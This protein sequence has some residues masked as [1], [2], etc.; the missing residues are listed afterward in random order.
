MTRKNEWHSR[1]LIADFLHEVYQTLDDFIKIRLSHM[2]ESPDIAGT[3]TILVRFGNVERSMNAARNV[4]ADSAIV[5][6]IQGGPQRRLMA[7][8]GDLGSLVRVVLK[9]GDLFGK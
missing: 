4:I 8:E 9:V 5:D 7:L 2:I 1:I 3:N 6:N